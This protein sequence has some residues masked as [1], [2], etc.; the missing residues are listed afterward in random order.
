MPEALADVARP[1]PGRA[2]SSSENPTGQTHSSRCSRLRR[3][4][5]R[6]DCWKR[7]PR[8]ASFC[9]CSAVPPASSYPS[10]NIQGV[11]LA[12]NTNEICI[13][14]IRRAMLGVELC[15]RYLPGY[16]ACLLRYT[17]IPRLT[18]ACAPPTAT[19]VAFLLFSQTQMHLPDFRYRGR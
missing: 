17:G 10:P 13:L 18:H 12:A 6:M 1:T 14:S 5:H 11:G 2:L 15:L 3:H 7:W 9:G 16:F 19:A 8:A 4:S